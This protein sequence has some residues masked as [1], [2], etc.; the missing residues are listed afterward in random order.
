[1][2]VHSPTHKTTLSDRWR[3]EPVTYEIPLFCFCMGKTGRWTDT[4]LLHRCYR[5]RRYCCDSP[6]CPHTKYFCQSCKIKGSSACG[7]KATKQWITDQ[8]HILPNS[9]WQHITFTINDKL[10]PSFNNSWALLNRL[11][12]CAAR[13]L[14]KLAEK[15]SIEIRFLSP[16]I[17]TGVN[18]TNTRISIY[19]WPA[20]VYVANTTSGDQVFF[21]KKVVER[22]WRWA[23]TVLLREITAAWIYLQPDMC[24]SANNRN[25][26]S[27]WDHSISGIDK[28]TLRKKT[29]T[30]ERY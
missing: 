6:D 15:L 19:Q 10:W 8:Q 9:E 22:Y 21:K 1:M 24:I 11:L 14:M 26:V 7:M 3:L 29:N 23:V 2:H 20:A 12:A 17:Q 5:Y 16:C 18:S 27:F 30:P 28:F 13:T 4:N 25:V